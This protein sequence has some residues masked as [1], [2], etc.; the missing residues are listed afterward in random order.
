[1]EDI[2]DA[3]YAHTKNVCKDFEI[4]SIGEDHELYIQIHTLLLVDVFENFRSMC[5]KT[6]ELDPQR[7]FSEPGLARQKAF[8]KTKGKLDLLTDIDV[9][10]MV[11]T[12]IRGA[13]CHSLY[14]YTKANNKYMK[15]YDK[16]KK[17][18][19]IQYWDV[20]NLYC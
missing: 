16:N 9:L 10:L 2:T 6:Y 8:K 19:C 13:I 5:L 15:D 18:S 11:E 1:M 12:G 14:Q 4:K 20:N 17:S 7:S 3:D